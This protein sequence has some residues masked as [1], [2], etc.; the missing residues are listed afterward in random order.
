MPTFPAT[1]IEQILGQMKTMIEAAN[2]HTAFGL[3]E[4]FT[5]R[6]YRN[7]VT[8]KTERPCIAIRLVDDA[9]NAEIPSGDAIYKAMTVDFVVDME[10]IPEADGGSGEDPTGWNALAAVANECSSIFLRENN[11]LLEIVGDTLAGDTDPDEDSTPDEG[12]LAQSIVV[13]YSVLRSDL[14]QLFT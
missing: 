4:P 14:N 10:L 6:H 11:D 3:A 7:R 1:P 8:Q 9:L 5:V 13:L 12:R 2:L